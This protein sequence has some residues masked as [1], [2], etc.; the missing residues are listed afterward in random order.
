[1]KRTYMVIDVACGRFPKHFDDWTPE[2]RMLKP[3]PVYAIAF[4]CPIVGTVTHLPFDPDANAD[5]YV[6]VIEKDEEW[7]TSLLTIFYEALRTVDCIVAHNA[8]TD[9]WLL[10]QTHRQVFGEPW[11]YAGDFYC[12]MKEGLIYSRCHIYRGGKLV[13]KWPH[14]QALC[15]TLLDVGRV[16]KGDIVDDVLQCHFCA[17]VM[18]D[19]QALAPA[20]Q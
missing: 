12:T 13:P 5:D 10:D 11:H 6:L 18:I 4:S 8:E 15:A 19:R 16:S 3:I 17:S 1:M 2:E 9:L 7:D 20:V 14:L